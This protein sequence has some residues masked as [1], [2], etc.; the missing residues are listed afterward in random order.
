[1]K[2][3]WKKLVLVLCT[4]LTI[5]T[6]VSPVLAADTR[7][8]GGAS[9]SAAKTISLNR[10]YTTTIRSSQGYSIFKFKTNSGSYFYELRAYNVSVAR[11]INVYLRGADRVDAGTSANNIN[12]QKGRDCGIH[13]RK[14]PLKANSWYYITIRNGNRSSGTVRFEVKAAKDIEGN[15]KSVAKSV[16]AGSTYYGYHTFP[17]DEDYFKFVPTA[18]G[19]YRVHVKN[20]STSGYIRS[21]VQTAGGTMLASKQFFGVNDYFSKTLR[22]TRGTAYYIHVQTGNE[23]WSDSNTKYRVYIQKR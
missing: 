6:S 15:I 17:Y 5:G 18:T 22:M 20:V 16:S 13:T 7:V 14:K 21:S 8:T 12:L 11:P 1:M 10:K 23:E 19:N 9:S 2:G 3:S 4:V